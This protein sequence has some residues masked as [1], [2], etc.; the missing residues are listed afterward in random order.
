MSEI[1]GTAEERDLLYIA[2]DLKQYHFCP[3]ITYYEKCLPDFRPQTYMMLA[4]REAHE[5]EQARALRRTLHAYR[6]VEGERHFDVHLRSLTLG[7]AGK[8]DEVVLA[9]GDPP[10][11]YPVDYKLT[12]QVQDQHRCQLA[13]YGLLLEEEWQVTVE[14]GF[15]YLI[16]RRKAVEVIIDAPLRE[17]VSHTLADIRA[18]A[19][20][21]VLPPPPASRHPCQTCEFRRVCNDR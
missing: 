13:A 10:R 17:M 11:A 4:G 1:G 6:L 2:T 7:L 19:E 16:P 21:E 14:R 8:I 5:R 3:R 9:P 20:R 18:I 12:P 15:I